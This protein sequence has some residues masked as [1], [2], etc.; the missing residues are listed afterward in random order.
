MLK[1]PMINH[2]EFKSFDTGGILKHWGSDGS[3]NC[4]RCKRFVDT[5]SHHVMTKSRGGTKTVQV[6]RR[7]HEWIGRHPKRAEREG[8][9]VRGYKINKNDK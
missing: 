9:Y 3:A 8:F 1:I 4:A 2:I 5:D 7:C 6:C